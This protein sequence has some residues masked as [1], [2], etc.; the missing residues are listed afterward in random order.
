MSKDLRGSGRVYQR[1]YRDGTRNPIWWIQYSVQGHLHRESSRSTERSAAVTLLRSRIGEG[2]TGRPIIGPKAERLMLGEMLDALIARYEADGRGASARMAKRARLHLTRHFGEHARAIGITSA[3]LD[4]YKL[5]RQAMLATTRVQK[6]PDGT[7][8]RIKV[9]P[10][11]A[12]INRELAILRIAFNRALESNLLARD[13]IPVIHLLSEKHAVRAGFIDPPEFE[14]L[15]AALPAVLKDPIQFLY[16]TSWRCGAM[17][18]LEWRDLEL[19][20]AGASKR[21]ITGGR[22]HLRA[23]NSKTGCAQTLPLEGA[24]L[25]I[26]QRAWAKRRPA[27]PWVFHRAG[28]RIGDFRKAWATACKKAG[29]PGLLVHDLRRSGIRNLLRAGV[30]ER[31]AMGI[32]G[33]RT[34]AVFDR[35]NIASE[36]DLAAAMLSV[37][38]Y[39]RERAQE[40]PKLVAIRSRA[41]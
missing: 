36:T 15:H 31:I 13:H 12:T 40:R 41:V 29:L 6:A 32:S 1:T 11:S 27:C 22:I 24:L 19:E 18:S 34:R 23:E 5:A 14:R 4:A 26:I 17:R 16:T 37:A 9:A 35:Y 25:A 8:V 21:A 30:P 39:H 2:A 3:K 7:A 28:A 20:R 38:T 10:A 33:H